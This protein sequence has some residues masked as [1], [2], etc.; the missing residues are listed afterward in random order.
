MGD[1]KIMWATQKRE[2]SVNLPLEGSVNL[3][4][5][6]LDKHLEALVQHLGALVLGLV[7][8]EAPLVEIFSLSHNPTTWL[9]DVLSGRSVAH[10]NMNRRALARAIARCSCWLV[11]A[12]H[13]QN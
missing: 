2:D 6:G 10:G 4:L 9:I 12:G 3:P 8:Q 7:R 1:P 11:V 13:V 5:E